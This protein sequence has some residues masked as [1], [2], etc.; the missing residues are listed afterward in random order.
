M[1]DT[2]TSSA[3]NPQVVVDRLL[4][5]KKRFENMRTAFSFRW[6]WLV[7]CALIWGGFG[8]AAAYSENENLLS[9]NGLSYL[10]G[11]L[12]FGGFAYWVVIAYCKMLSGAMIRIQD[13][14]LTGAGIEKLQETLEEDFFTKLVKINFK[15]IDQYYLQTQSQADKA[16][17]LTC[18][19]ATIGLLTVIAGIVLMFMGKTTPAYLSAGSGVIA[20]FISAVF[21]Y[22][23]NR[24]VTKMAQYHQKLVITQNIG[25]AM[26]IAE[27]LPEPARVE[28]QKELVMRLTDDVNRHLTELPGNEGRFAKLPKP[29]AAER[30]PTAQ[31]AQ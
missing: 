6:Y 2:Q 26:K 3:S 28:A 4:Q 21:F 17:L 10:G 7:L 19:V 20:Q 27:G 22:L 13:S 16:F 31:A 1:A 29:A 25:L 5:A 14:L 9:I 18:F 8:V 11:G 12:V 24:T 23:Y 15:Y 30:S